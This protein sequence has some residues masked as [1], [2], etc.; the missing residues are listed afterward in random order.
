MSKR[1]DNLVTRLRKGDDKTLET[2]QSL[3][4][5]QWQSVLYEEPYPWTVRDMAAH[6]L[7]T[8]K[9][10]RRVAQNIAGGGPG[11]PQGFDY[12]AHNAE[13]QVRLA[14]IPPK[15]LLV[16]LADARAATIAWVSELDEAV[17]DRTGHHPALGEITLETLINVIHG[18]Q[19]M[20][21]RDLRAL[22][23]SA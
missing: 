4:G 13:E 5:T 2:L 22:L 19:L 6:F 12:D 15:R 7:S 20:H 3:S 14:G 18:H 11:A 1:V 9:G 16:S 21:L 17:L 23:R 10:L 8:E